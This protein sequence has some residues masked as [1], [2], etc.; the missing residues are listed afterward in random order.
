MSSRLQSGCDEIGRPLRIYLAG[1]VCIE[2]SHSLLHERQLAGPQG[3]HLLALLAAEH[4]RPVG[5]DEIVEELWGTEPPDAWRQSLKALASRTRAA[6]RAAGLDGPALLVG[7]PAVYRLRLPEDAW[8]DIEAAVSA[9]HAAETSLRNGDPA[10]AV[11]EAFVARLISVRRLLP[12]RDGPWVESRR[13]ALADVRVRALECAARARIALGAPAQAIHDL[14]LVLE[15]EPLREP[16]WR[17][18]MDA[19]AASGDVASALAAYENCRGTLRETLGV[20]P[21]AATRAHH[22]ALL[23]LAS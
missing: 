16:T 18:L 9:V 21:S 22:E 1:E 7:A 15:I 14:R 19:H 12:G 10:A 13:R 2:T 5:H 17:L 6:L 11:R 4:H 20:A 23:A 3:R 8:I